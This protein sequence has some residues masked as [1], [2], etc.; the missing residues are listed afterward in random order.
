MTRLSLTLHRADG[1][2]EAVDFTATH[3]VIAGWT[4]RDRAALDHHIAE[5]AA[6]GIPGPSTV[7]V[8]YRAAAARLTQAAAI[9]VL[10]EASS[11]EA[12]FVLFN[13]GGEILV[14]IGSDHTDR[15]A[16]RHGIALSKQLCCKPLGGDVWAFADVAAHWDRLELSSIADGTPYQQGTLAALRPAA[17][18]LGQPGVL[19]EGGVIFGGTMPAIGGIRP[20]A[21]FAYRLHDPVLG[22]S[23]HAAYTMVT[24]P[25]IR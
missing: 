25:I 24:L 22:R 12:E 16:E 13:H 17:E 2:R 18:L 4:G 9:E 21:A 8:Y 15:E 7:P 6:L 10:G 1:R 3:L 11:G 20:A 5:L 23:L 14:G 19:P